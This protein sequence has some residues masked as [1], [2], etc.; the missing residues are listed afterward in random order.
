MDI[1]KI[2]KKLKQAE[3][4]VSSLMG[5]LVV[6]VVALLIFKYFQGLGKSLPILTKPEEKPSTQTSS[7]SPKNHQVALGENLWQISL[8]YYNSGYNWTDI[9]KANKLTDPNKIFVGETLVIPYVEPKMVKESSIT[10]TSQKL[11]SPI[12]QNEYQVVKGDNLWDISV[13][14]YGDGFQWPKISQANKLV[15]PGLIHSGNVLVIPR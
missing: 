4:S 14:A 2:L 9:A 15:N 7:E 1:K 13:R 5:V 8:K 3:Q 6:L 11:S 10:I 12:T